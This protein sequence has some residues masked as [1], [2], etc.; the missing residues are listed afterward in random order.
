MVDTLQETADLTFVTK[1][2]DGTLNVW[3]PERP[4]DYGE[5]CAM[6]RD[7]A[8]EF[9]AHVRFNDDPSLLGAIIREISRVGYGAVEV[10]FMQGIATA[11]LGT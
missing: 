5:A 3:T 4:A 6:G 7:Y 1:C 11:L 9:I 2:D 10:G 8:A